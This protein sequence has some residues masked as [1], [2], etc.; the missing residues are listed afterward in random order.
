MAQF[1]PEWT[2]RLPLL[3]LIFVLVVITG[4]VGGIWYFGSPWYTDVGYRPKQPVPYSHKL[5]AGD[6]GIDCRYCHTSVETSAYANVPPVATCMN[7]HRVV[8][9]TSDTLLPV[10]ESFASGVPIQ[11]VRVTQLPGYAYFDHSAHIN[12][13]VG[14]ITCHGNVAEMETVTLAKPMSMGW[15][16]SC[17]R[18]PAPNLRP[19]S[20][21]TNMWYQPPPNQLA[22]GRKIIKEKNLKPPEDC[23]GCHR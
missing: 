22:L 14:C 18:N 11:W 15:C 7:C 17:H 1:L 2:N 4:V 16:L 20:E 23:S 10:R 3:T 9:A 19:V 12:A 13:G 6:L 8:K 21:V 5:H